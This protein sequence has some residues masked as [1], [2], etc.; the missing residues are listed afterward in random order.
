MVGWIYIDGICLEYES[1]LP[2]QIAFLKAETRKTYLIIPR[3]DKWRSPDDD[4]YRLRVYDEVTVHY[5]DGEVE[6]YDYP[7][8]NLILVNPGEHF[9]LDD[10]RGVLV[11]DYRR[12]LW[13]R[14]LTDGGYFEV[15]YHS[16]LEDMCSEE[17]WILG[18]ALEK[19]EEY[20]KAG[21]PVNESSLK[22]YRRF[23]S[24]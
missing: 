16:R 24:V 3:L 15:L 19:L 21:K 12:N 18:K 8:V 1:P 23:K 10:V 6:V 11:Y 13:G 14:F 22:Y 20:L 5:L 4:V 2:R 17:R 9:V 7:L